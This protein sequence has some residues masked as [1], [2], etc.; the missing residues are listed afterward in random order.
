M[1]PPGKNKVALDVA[2][3]RETGESLSFAGFITVQDQEQKSYPKQMNKLD[4]EF[5]FSCTVPAGR[6]LGNVQK[7]GQVVQHQRMQAKVTQK[8][9][10]DDAGRKVLDKL[11]R[12]ER[13]QAKQ[14]RSVGKRIFKSFFSPCRECHLQNSVIQSDVLPVESVKKLH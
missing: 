8:R 10:A 11:D 1:A 3:D 2:A 5:E 7:S 6:N 14:K 9:A 12:R 13:N 4:E